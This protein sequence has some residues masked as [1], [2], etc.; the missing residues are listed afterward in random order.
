MAYYR[1]YLL[2]EA[3]GRFVGFEE[4]EAADDVEA[5]RFAEDHVGEHPLELWCGKRKVKSFP[6]AISD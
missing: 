2:A 5:V 3:G 4:I 1:L 6:A